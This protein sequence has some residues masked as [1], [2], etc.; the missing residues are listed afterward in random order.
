MQLD[1]LHHE[2]NPHCRDVHNNP[3][4]LP[5]YERGLR[6][7][8]RPSCLVRGS[9]GK[10]AGSFSLA[11]MTGVHPSGEILRDQWH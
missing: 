9:C 5:G 2:I 4:F 7:Q 6:S 11:Q 8:H 1:Y 3:S 10:K